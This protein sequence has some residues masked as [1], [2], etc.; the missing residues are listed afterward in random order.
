MELNLDATY[1][2]VTRIVLSV[3]VQV[4]IAHSR[5]ISLH[6]QSSSKENVQINLC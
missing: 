6:T 3:T 1:A 5:N 4:V 2:L